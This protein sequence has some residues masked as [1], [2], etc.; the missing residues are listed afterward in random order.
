MG[1]LKGLTEEMRELGMRPS[2]RVLERAI[3]QDRIVSSIFGRPS[4]ASF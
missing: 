3:V 1:R 2:T 4:T